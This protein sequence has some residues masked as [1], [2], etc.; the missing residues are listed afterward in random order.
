MLY[1]E[2][3][4]HFPNPSSQP[5]RRVWETSSNLCYE[6]EGRIQNSGEKLNLFWLAL[7]NDKTNDTPLLE[8]RHTSARH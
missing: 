6:T 8:H 3:N 5:R 1:P 7:E 4:C 2:L